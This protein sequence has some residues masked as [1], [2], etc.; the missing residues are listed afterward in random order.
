MSDSF[1][2]ADLSE[3]DK[4]L[5]LGMYERFMD[6]SKDMLKKDHYKF[7][8]QYGADE[9]IQWGDFKDTYADDIKRSF[10][11]FRHAGGMWETYE[12]EGNSDRDR[13]ETAWRF[14]EGQVNPDQMEST[15]RAELEDEYALKT[16]SNYEPGSSIP[17]TP[18]Y[19]IE[20]EL[21]DFD[22]DKGL[23]PR[24]ELKKPSVKRF[25]IPKS[26]RK[27]ADGVADNEPVNTAKMAIKGL[28][29]AN[30]NPISKL[31]FN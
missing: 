18:K 4:N 14:V 15:I 8:Y 3:E 16:E 30:K 31:K 27:Y 10:L 29:K 2:I 11:Q 19:K 24:S 7:R 23:T 25:K 1:S 13:I 6:D 17:D 21:A 20:R 22:D 5:R 12:F 26:V 28:S 9:V